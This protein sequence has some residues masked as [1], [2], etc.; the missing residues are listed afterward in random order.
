[1]G[2]LRAE[3]NL[4]ENSLESLERSRD[5]SAPYTYG[6][7]DSTA[8][9]PFTDVGPITLRGNGQHILYVDD[10]EP[11]VFLVTRLLTLLGYRVSAFE[12][13]DD[14]MEA[15]RDTPQ[16]FDLVV[17]DFN[18]PGASGLDVA[19]AVSNVRS[20]LP[21]VITSGYI[22]E[23]LLSGARAVGVQYLIHKPNTVDELCSVLQR[24]IH[25]KS[26]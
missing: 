26:V 14:A 5:P 15:V 16:S 24:V 21:V 11:M 10:D 9:R 18:M 8:L 3:T 13:A 6:P 19:R 7:L 4:S 1:M 12:R 23:E 17:T 22:N 2:S 25:E 20:D